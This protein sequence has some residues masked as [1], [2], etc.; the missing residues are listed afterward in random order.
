MTTN[1]RMDFPAMYRIRV[2]GLIDESWFSF[3]DD[4]VIEVETGTLKH[5]VTT[6]TGRIAD[7]TAL[8]GMLNLL[9]ELRLPLLSVECLLSANHDAHKLDI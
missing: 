4:M 3:Y 7:Q 2:H 5:P 1:L 8:Q 9:Y 6:L